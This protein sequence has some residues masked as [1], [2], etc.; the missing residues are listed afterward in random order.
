MPTLLKF[1]I[2]NIYILFIYLSIYNIILDLK[3]GIDIRPILT[4]CY[5]QNIYLLLMSV[6]VIIFYINML[7]T[8]RNKIFYELLT[9]LYLNIGIYTYVLGF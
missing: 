2:L 3:L 5:L 1:I 9:C 8:C 4:Y 7:G 6:C